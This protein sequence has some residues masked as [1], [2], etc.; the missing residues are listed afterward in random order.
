M[1]ENESMTEPPRR[2]PVI[3]IVDDD[4]SVRAATAN[5]VAS[6]GFDACTFPSA[7]EFLQSAGLNETS[8][9][10][11]EVGMPG[12]SGMALQRALRDRGRR[13]PTIFVTA[14][15]GEN[16]KARAVAEGAVCILT[17]PFETDSLIRC[18]NAALGCRSG[19]DE[20]R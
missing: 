1:P 9:L 15:A 2:R 18:I 19:S 17:K 8:C 12:M 11:T 16:I 14:F 13:L 20:R 5:L 3:S 6:L 10:I 4:E 7:E